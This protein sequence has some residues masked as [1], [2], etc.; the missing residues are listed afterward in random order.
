MLSSTSLAESNWEHPTNQNTAPLNICIGETTTICIWVNVGAVFQLC[1]HI[2]IIFSANCPGTLLLGLSMVFQIIKQQV[3]V[4]SMCNSYYRL[5]LMGYIS[6]LLTIYAMSSTAEADWNSPR[7]L[8]EW[9]RGCFVTVSV[10]PVPTYC[11]KSATWG[12]SRS[13]GEAGNLVELRSTLTSIG[14]GIPGESSA[15][16][17]PW[18]N[19]GGWTM[20]SVR[21][22]LNDTGTFTQMVI[23]YMMLSTSWC[24]KCYCHQYI[25]TYDEDEPWCLTLAYSYFGGFQ[26]GVLETMMLE[27]RNSFEFPV[28]HSDCYIHMHH[29]SGTEAKP[30]INQ[31]NLARNGVNSNLGRHF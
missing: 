5:L 6:G 16:L 22:C 2:Q 18:D 20:R 19:C 14:D 27:K 24:H 17:S 10:L 13:T 8:T 31:T 4:G 29:W 9:R 11:D 3:K 28:W 30:K 23:S 15:L 26:C 7:Q 25:I 1:N 21:V 12:I